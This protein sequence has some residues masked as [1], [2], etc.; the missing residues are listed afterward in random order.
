MSLYPEGGG[1]YDNWINATS[2]GRYMFWVDAGQANIDV[3]AH[4]AS[5]PL[6]NH[7]QAVTITGNMTVDINV[8]ARSATLSGV[9]TDGSQPL[10]WVKVLAENVTRGYNAVTPMA[11]TTPTGAYTLYL[12][13]GDTYNISFEK[14]GYEPAGQSGVVAG[15][16]T[17]AN[18]ELTL[19]S[20]APILSGG[21]VT[22]A[23]GSTSDAFV[24]EVTYTDEDN[25]APAGVFVSVDGVQHDMTRADSNSYASGSKYT[26]STTLEGGSHWFQFEAM[27]SNYVSAE[28]ADCE[29]E[30]H[31]GPCVT[32]PPSPPVNESF[33]PFSGQYS[34]G[35]QQTFSCE[36]SDPNGAA[37]LA[38]CKVIINTTLSGANCIH[39]RYD[40]NLNML[41]VRNDA[42]TDWG[43]GYAPGAPNVLENGYC[44]VYC[45]DTTVSA[46]ETGLTV[47]WRVEPKPTM[48]GKNCT[49]WLFSQDDG[50]LTDGWDA[51][52]T[53][54]FVSSPIN[55]SLTPDS[56]TFV[57]G[58]PGTLAAKFFDPDGAANLKEC[59]VLLGQMT[60]PCLS[61]TVK[62]DANQNKL[63]LSSADESCNWLGGYAPGSANTIENDYVKIYCDQSSVTTLDNDLTVTFVAEAKQVP[64]MAEQPVPASMFCV[65]DQ[66]HTDGWDQMGSYYF[67]SPPQN[68]AIDPTS[69]T[70]VTGLKYA[71]QTV[72][73]DADTTTNL[74]ECRLLVNTVLN[75]A[76]CVNVRYDA[77]AGLLYVRNND[78]TGW[79]GGYAPGSSNVIENGYCKLHCAET[80]VVELLDEIYIVWRIEPKAGMA[81]K[82][83]SAWLKV[84]DDEGYY[85]GWEQFGGTFYFSNNRQPAVVSMSPTGG[86]W[87][88]DTQQVF[89]CQYSD[90]DGYGNIAEARLLMNNVL[91]GAGCVNVMYNAVENRLYVRTD[92]NT[93]W[94][95]GHAPGTANVI[96][97]GF[98]RLNCAGSSVSGV[99][100]V[101]TVNFAVE[102]KQAFSGRNAL[103]WMRVTDL[104]GS[105]DGWDQVGYTYKFNQP[106]TNVSISPTSTSFIPGVRKTITSQYSD[107]DGYL[108]IGEYRLLINNTLSGAGCI[109]VMYDAVSNKL[110]V[111]N[112]D[113]TAWLGGYAP[114]TA[115]VVENSYCKL[116]C[117][118]TTRSYS[119]TGYTINWKIEAKPAMA[120]RNC[121]AWMR[122]ADNC[123]AVDGWEQFG[124]SFK[125]NVP[126]T[127]GSM[128][129]QGAPPAYIFVPGL[130]RTITCQYSDANGYADLAECRLLINTVLSGANCIHLM[131]DANANLLYVRNNANTAW[132]GGYAPG[133]PYTISNSY[134]SLNCGATTVS[135]SDNTLTVNWRFE[136]KPTM[137]PRICGAW[138]RVTDDANATANW[139]E[140]AR[141]RFTYPPVDVSI[142]PASGTL[143]PGDVY[144]FT[145]VYSDADGFAD[146]TEC[147]LL[148]NTA[149][150]GRNC[151]NVLYN[152]GTQALYLRNDD[153][154]AWL[155]GYA[156]GSLET[157]E[158][159]YC[160]L[161]CETTTAAGDGNSLTVVW[162]IEPKPAFSGRACRSWLRCA[163]STGTYDGWDRLGA[164]TFNYT[165][166]AGPLSPDTGELAPEEWNAIF[167]SYTDA[168][169]RGHLAECRL[170]INTVLSGANCFHGM[171]DPNANLL[172]LRNDANTAWL[173][174]YA[175]G[176]A[177][178]V[179]NTFYRL[180]CAGVTVEDIV[181]G[182]QIKWQVWPKMAVAGTAPGA[183]VRAGDE[184]WSTS[185]WLEAGAYTIGSGPM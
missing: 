18:A 31:Q 14:P 57:V 143:T 171:Y 86:T 90:P 30:W 85:D 164:I 140:K 63:Y 79:I 166:V 40:A 32:V 49:A 78:N 2:Q 136:P 5:T 142:A 61:P 110:Y 182:I 28:L 50:G 83:C 35:G 109:H 111:R 45:A 172:Y 174:G 132:L 84:T 48:S 118:E 167:A 98:C 108:N 89:T 19:I 134:V 133:S 103:A 121:G 72:F 139:T 15:V 122:V 69:G 27:D 158:N 185:G 114:G 137:S 178:V 6:E 106:P 34:T 141:Y 119:G 76:S 101:L 95:G 159:S 80:D 147:R 100:N 52:G 126:P 12:T 184:L 97:N 162:Q 36:Y 170:L 117:A 37:N 8:P 179:E 107:P 25:D 60:D 94:V 46:S 26:Y 93:G 9:V 77:N 127:N 53:A 3:Y 123:G 131:Y 153:N 87:P 11:Y 150:D 7:S 104:S 64:P 73:G 175:P 91:N 125:V 155:G 113:N 145:T 112:N 4:T 124:G 17:T 20:H 157:I 88:P 146:L 47:N 96:E 135:G 74:A 24:F 43:T 39:L 82:S 177:N 161:H 160:K 128:V 129:A 55:V 21:K 67:R 10:Q 51:L 59:F 68:L 138:M 154:T 120:G 176:S 13:P 92:A 144:A 54:S 115:N 130:Q 102:A 23:S 44:R 71:V 41:Y 163:D 149:L 70:F 99:G 75:G 116:Y 62:Y 22:P 29:P 42:N 81:G 38:E 33:M 105:T 156:I 56:A 151:I 66:E 165:P 1:Q 148:I 168:D 183:W 152:P 180:D 16:T 169:G 173:G 181:D 58:Q 65:D